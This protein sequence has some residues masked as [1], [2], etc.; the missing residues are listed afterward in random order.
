[1]QHIVAIHRCL[2]VQRDIQH[3]QE[4]ES[5]APSFKSAKQTRYNFTLWRCALKTRLVAVVCCMLIRFEN[6]FI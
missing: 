6:M 2:H 1:M 3:T 4:V 5:D